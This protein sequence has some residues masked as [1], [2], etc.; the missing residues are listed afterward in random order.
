MSILTHVKP[1]VVELDWDNGEASK[2]GERTLDAGDFTVDIEYTV[3]G[4]RLEHPGDYFQPPEYQDTF[5]KCVAI[6]TVWDDEGEPVKLTPDQENI[7]TI[8]IEEEA[9]IS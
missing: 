2:S 7:L 5:E 3:T 4:S 9:E 6:L 1:L 8:T